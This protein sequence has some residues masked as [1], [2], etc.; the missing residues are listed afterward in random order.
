MLWMPGVEKIVWNKVMFKLENMRDL[1]RNENS[2]VIHN[3]CSAD[4][5]SK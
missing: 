4:M 3:A 5:D 1:I 2:T